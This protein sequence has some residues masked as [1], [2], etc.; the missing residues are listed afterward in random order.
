MT[1]LAD[2]RLRPAPS[3]RAVN[4]ICLQI[5]SLDIGALPRFFATHDMIELG[6]LLNPLYFIQPFFVTAKKYLTIPFYYLQT[7][8]ASLMAA[9]LLSTNY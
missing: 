4:I 7:P 5:S 8:P 2:T 1:P 6:V 3:S 9:R